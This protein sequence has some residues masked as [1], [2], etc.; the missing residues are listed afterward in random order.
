MKLPVVWTVDLKERKIRVNAI[1]PDPIDTPMTSSAAQSNEQ[2][3]QLKRN[4]VSTSGRMGG[5][6]C[7]SFRMTVVMSPVSN[8]S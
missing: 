6:P 5:P 3:E 1:S 2:A 8:C 7:S 4:F